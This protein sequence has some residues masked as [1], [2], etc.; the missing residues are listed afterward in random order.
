MTFKTEVLLKQA[1][2]PFLI[3]FPSLKMVCQKE[4]KPDLVF[5]FLKEKTDDRPIPYLNF[6]FVVL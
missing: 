6:K 4:K 5:L 3:T 1:K 2:F